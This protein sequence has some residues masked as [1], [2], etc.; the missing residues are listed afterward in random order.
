MVRP[1]EAGS[2]PDGK[3]E[4][5]VEFAWNAIPPAFMENVRKAIW[6]D[7]GGVPGVWANFST[8]AA[9]A[10]FGRLPFQSGRL[11]HLVFGC[12]DRWRS[13]GQGSRW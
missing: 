9:G 6:E 1:D 3:V 2:F 8:G 10:G 7:I 11:G 12:G 4:M 13:S 5:G